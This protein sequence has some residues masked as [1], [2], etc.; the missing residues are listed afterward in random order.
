MSSS[1][2]TSRRARPAV[3]GIACYVY[4]IVPEDVDVSPD[5]VGVGDPPGRVRLIRHGRIGALVSDVAVDRPLGRA[6]DLVGHEALL[7]GTAAEVP[8]LPL[9]FGAVLTS[10]EAVV[11]E[12]LEPHHDEFAAALKEVEGHVQYV[13]RATYAERWVLNEILAENAEIRRLRDQVR[14][15][16]EDATRNERIR[17]GELITQAIAVKRE[18]D[19]QTVLDCFAPCTVAAVVRD[20]AHERDAANVAFMV[21]SDQE[22]DFE[23]VLGELRREWADRIDV[24]VLGP[25]AVYDFVTSG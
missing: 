6:E 15:R 21:R 25:M 24:R 20:P 16:P 13:I 9:R 12:L 22:D 18:A 10:P 3:E 19:T 1:T 17:I 5:A 8:V 14:G 11:G 7:N 4:G 2:E 23:M